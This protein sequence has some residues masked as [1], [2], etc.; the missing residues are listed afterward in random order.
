M[1]VNEIKP[2]AC[3]LEPEDISSCRITQTFSATC[4]SRHLLGWCHRR[5][6]QQLHGCC[7][8]G[9]ECGH[10][11]LHHVQRPLHDGDVCGIHICR[12]QLPQ[13]AVSSLPLGL[14]CS[15]RAP[16]FSS[17]IGIHSACAS[18][19]TWTHKRS[20][21]MMFQQTPCECHCRRNA[22]G[23]RIIT[24][25]YGCST[26]NVNAC[27]SQ[28]FEKAIAAFKAQG[29]LFIASAGNSGTSNDKVGAIRNLSDEFR[30]L[31]V[32]SH[33]RASQDLRRLHMPHDAASRQPACLPL[34]LGQ[35]AAR[36]YQ[37]FIVIR[38]SF[39]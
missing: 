19:H 10:C 24:N 3:N 17:C 2:T 6:R 36:P 26:A 5:N 20:S 32:S 14:I 38:L 30:S 25:S 39:S 22:R 31:Q 21:A 27:Y 12:H 34:A 37:E 18:G 15:F 13:L 9:M 33:S 29:G 1:H 35:S 23:V 8:R 7:G 16:A 11:W 28:Q 4:R